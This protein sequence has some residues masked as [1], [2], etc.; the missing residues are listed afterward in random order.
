MNSLKFSLNPEDFASERSLSS[1]DSYEPGIASED[2]SIEYPG[3]L[4]AV[5]EEEH[6]YEDHI[7]INS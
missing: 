1:S 5:A 3:N 4:D 2:D 6:L 7:L